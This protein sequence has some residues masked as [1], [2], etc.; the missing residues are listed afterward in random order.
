MRTFA[1]APGRLALGFLATATCVVGLSPAEATVAPADSTVTIQA[2]GTDLFGKVKSPRASCK[3]DRF[4]VLFKV[5]GTRGGGDDSHFAND[6]TDTDGDWN[7]G[8][9]GTPGRYYAKVRKTPNCQ[10]DSSP[11]IRVTR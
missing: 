7:T 3:A 9:T 2:E 11:T 4:V 1:S 8:N 5:I 6:T 10:A